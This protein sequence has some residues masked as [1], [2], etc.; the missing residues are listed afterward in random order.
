MPIGGLPRTARFRSVEQPA[1]IALEF[2]G[3]DRSGFYKAAVAAVCDLLFD[4]VETPGIQEAAL[5]LEAAG[6]DEEEMLVDLLN[7]LLHRCQV[8]G[9]RPARIDGVRF[10]EPKRIIMTLTGVYERGDFARREL[11]REIKAATY[12]N[13]KVTRSPVW[14]ARVVFDV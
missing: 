13:L 14:R 6:F 8:T 10:P 5:S 9:W 12:H 1:D 3:T 11:K 4:S 7:E 2:E